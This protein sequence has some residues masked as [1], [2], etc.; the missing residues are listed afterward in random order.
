MTR[1]RWII[2]AALCLIIFG[3]VI[4]NNKPETVTYKGDPTK[5]IDEGPIADHVFGSSE[6]KVVLIEYGDLQC[7]ACGAIFPY[8]KQIKDQYKDHLTFVFRDMPLTNIHPNAL[9]AATAAEAAGL[10]G[11]FFEMHDIL[12][13][14]Q[15]TWQ[16]AQLNERE[17]LFESFAKRIGLDINRFKND[18]S[19]PD[20]QQKIAR[21][22]ATSKHFDVTATP[23]FVL[24][25]QKLPESTGTNGDKLRK[26]VEDAL[27]QAGFT[28]TP[29]QPGTGGSGQ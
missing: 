8:M 23:T 17:G 2:F 18:L 15:S 26:A 13:E 20:I 12:Y 28:I 10:Q 3:L 4:L 5:V 7:P 29:A 6:R 22:K 16:S 11:K 21:D 14:N 27:Q 24:N 1:T 9:A 19:S 25:G